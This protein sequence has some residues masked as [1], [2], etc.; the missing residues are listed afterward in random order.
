MK[1]AQ[2]HVENYRKA[3][4]VANR[5]TKVPFINNIAKLQQALYNKGFYKGVIDKKRTGKQVTLERAVDGYEGDM[6]NQA[7]Q[8]AI[9]AGYTVNKNTGEITSPRKLA[10]GKTPKQ[11]QQQQQSS[12]FSFDKLKSL[13]KEFY[14][15][16]FGDKD[17][18]TGRNEQEEKNYQRMYN[19]PYSLELDRG[20]PMMKQ[21]TYPNGFQEYQYVE[22]VDGRPV[23]ESKLGKLGLFNR[24]VSEDG[25][26]CY[27]IKNDKGQIVTRCSETG[28]LINRALGL[29]TTGDAWNRYGVY[30]DTLIYGQSNHNKFYTRPVGKVINGLRPD[31]LDPNNLKTGDFVDLYTEGSG[32]NA[33]A[34]T[35]RGNSHTGTI[36]RPQGDKG[37]IYIIHGGINNRAYVDPLAR[38]G[39]TR[40]WSIMSVRRPGSKEHPYY[41]D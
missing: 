10:Y 33:E 2:N 35:G 21:I 26:V 14:G 13:G 20:E 40:T 37:P 34:A 38:F 32:H 30:G 39:P 15:R 9:N 16:V 6:T 24:E 19:T 22:G 8:N 27:Q 18:L 28:N 11:S 1:K 17:M 5:N 31:Q 23:Y 41:E 3:N 36:Y 29:P 25:K 4:K 7:I 12:T